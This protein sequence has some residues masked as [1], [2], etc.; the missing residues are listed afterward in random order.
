[1]TNIALMFKPWSDEEEERIR[2][3][4]GFVMGDTGRVNGLLAVSR[5][6]GDFYMHP[7]VTDDPYS[8]SYD[9]HDDDEQLII[10]CD[11]V[12]DE[13]SNARAVACVRKVD[14]PFLASCRLRDLAYCLASDD[15]ISVMI[16]KLKESP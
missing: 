9:I 16:V 14:D 1:M 4:G 12:W 5:S 15:N 8:A 2:S 10:A 7:W 11:G 13:L 6:I 3:L